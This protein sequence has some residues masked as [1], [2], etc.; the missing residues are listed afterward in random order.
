MYNEN[1]PYHGLF[2]QWLRGVQGHEPERFTTLR[3]R[4]FAAFAQAGVPTRKTE[5]W[6]YT[7]VRDLTTAAFQP[8]WKEPQVSVIS[9]SQ[10]QNNS[11]SWGDL[12]SVYRMVF[13]NGYYQESVSR[14]PD[15]GGEGFAGSWRKALH[16]PVWSKV[17]LEQWERLLDF[18]N[19]NPYQW[20]NQ[21]MAQDGA[22]LVVPP[23]IQE[24]VPIHLVFIAQPTQEVSWFQ[25]RNL[26]MVGAGS[27]LRYMESYAAWEPGV[28]YWSNAATSFVLEPSA[29]VEYTKIQNED[30]T[31]WHLAEVQVELAQNSVL[32]SYVFSWG[33]KHS[34]HEVE[35]LL[36]G[37]Q[38]HCDLNGLYLPRGEQ[39]MEN[40]ICMEHAA[41]HCT[42]NQYYKGILS[43]AGKGVFNGKIHVR[44]K[45]QKTDAYQTNQALLLSDEADM[46][47]KPQLEIFADDVKCSHGATSGYLD[48]QAM[49]YLQSRGI[50]KKE[51][52]TILTYAFASDVVQKVHDES[53]RHWLEM[54]LQQRLNYHL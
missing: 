14:L 53:L 23:A 1:T 22:F 20:L 19:A 41:P 30:A 3:Q 4:G 33:A 25:P 47:S 39:V 40:R 18:R 52:E 31:A 48:E 45:A 16:D 54:Q 32:E 24:E 7:S 34:R 29:H 46:Y 21:A 27:R 12:S 17:L 43:D 6:K 15:W 35:A 10:L 38:A 8:M 28:G 2:E 9:E 49:F 26:V 44:P 50:S 42:S 37:E 36:R 13:V 11:R 51:A 5:E